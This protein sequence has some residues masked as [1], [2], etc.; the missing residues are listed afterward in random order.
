MASRLKKPIPPVQS[1][2]DTLAAEQR[3]TR[4]EVSGVDDPGRGRVRD[5]S[6]RLTSGDESRNIGEP[7]ITDSPAAT[8]GRSWWIGTAASIFSR[9]PGAPGAG[10]GSTPEQNA[11]LAEKLMTIFGPVGENSRRLGKMFG[12]DSGEKSTLRER[13]AANLAAIT[14]PTVDAWRSAPVAAAAP[15]IREHAIDVEDIGFAGA[16]VTPPPQAL[17]RRPIGSYPSES[18]CIHDRRFKNEGRLSCVS[19]HRLMTYEVFR[20]AP[21]MKGLHREL[22]RRADLQQQLWTDRYW[23]AAYIADKA[24]EADIE[25]DFYSLPPNEQWGGLPSDKKIGIAIHEV[26]QERYLQY[27]SHKS[28]EIVSEIDQHVYVFGAAE[29]GG[30][31]APVPFWDLIPNDERHDKIGALAF[32]LGSKSWHLR[33]DIV[34]MSARTMIEIKPIRSL[35]KGVLQLWRYLSNFRL[36]MAWDDLVYPTIPEKGQ[37][38]NLYELVPGMVPPSLLGKIP[39]VETLKKKGMSPKELLKYRDYWA[40]PMMLSNLPGLLFYTLHKGKPSKVP[41]LIRLIVKGILIAAA[42][43]VVAVLVIKFLPAALELSGKLIAALVSIGKGIELIIDGRRVRLPALEE[44]SLAVREML[45]NESPQ[46]ALQVKELFL[47][48]R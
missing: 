42:F 11:A 2:G 10:E 38:P 3:A 19:K 23:A 6:G 37:P 40:Q 45:D 16:G 21:Q 36:A 43:A 32:S 8:L 35:H 30:R 26:L 18:K 7:G 15:P 12:V 14:A 22:Q 33:P 29:K 20:Q 24:S 13:V 44:S 27:A 39:L 4:I 17:K 25:D 47:A 46:I 34:D 9:L 5:P 41:E 31:P 48:S 28:H 1:G